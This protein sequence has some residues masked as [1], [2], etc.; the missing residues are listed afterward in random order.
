MMDVQILQ[1]CCHIFILKC[2]V[3]QNQT[4]GWRYCL[5]NTEDSGAISFY[6]DLDIIQLLNKI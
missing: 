5:T 2:N 6:F 4:R 1:D 3:E